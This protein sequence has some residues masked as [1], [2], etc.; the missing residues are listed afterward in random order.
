MLAGM[1]Q[2]DSNSI[3][4]QWSRKVPGMYAGLDSD[5]NQ[6]MEVYRMGNGRWAVHGYGDQ[7]YGTL[8]SAQRAAERVPPL[9]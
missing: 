9:R 1:D 8:K 3:V 2:P 4:A 7:T 5:G 6:V